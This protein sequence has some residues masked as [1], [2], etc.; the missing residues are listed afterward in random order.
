MFSS[1]MFRAGACAVLLCALYSTA[2]W[3]IPVEAAVFQLAPTWCVLSRAPLTFPSDLSVQRKRWSIFRA[4]LLSW[5]VASTRDFD[6]GQV[7]QNHHRLPDCHRQGRPK[8][9]SQEGP[10]DEAKEKDADADRGEGKGGP[11]QAEPLSDVSERGQDP[12][13]GQDGIWKP[14]GDYV[15]LSA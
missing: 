10:D 4:L 6:C 3:S 14:R 5:E 11:R 1:K 9:H 12:S 15:L 2:Q 7:S 8:N 13:R